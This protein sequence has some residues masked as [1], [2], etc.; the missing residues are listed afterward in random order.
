[1]E[2]SSGGGPVRPPQAHFVGGEA[3]GTPTGSA[4]EAIMERFCSNIA[5]KSMVYLKYT[6]IL[7]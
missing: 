5:K 1:L 7:Q 4:K 3:G 2:A 6:V